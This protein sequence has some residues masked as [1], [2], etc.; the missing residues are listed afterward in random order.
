M[1]TD[2]SSIPPPLPDE[3]VPVVIPVADYVE[4]PPPSYLGYWIGWG[5]FL[6]VYVALFFLG[7]RA[8]LFALTGLQYLPFLVLAV[9]AYLG[10]TNRDLRIL[11]FAYWL[12]LIVI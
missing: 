2:P 4:M 8:R 7:Y 6:I 3:P 10:D 5:V 9:L 11:T 1:A 12:L